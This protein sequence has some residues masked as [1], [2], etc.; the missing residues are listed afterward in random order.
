MTL[1]VSH[2]HFSVKNKD[3]HRFCSLSLLQHHV[4]GLEKSLTHAC[5]LHAASL[6]NASGDCRQ[7]LHHPQRQDWTHNAQRKPELVTMRKDYQTCCL[8]S[9]HH[10]KVRKFGWSLIIRVPSKLL[11]CA[12]VK[13]GQDRG[14]M[15]GRSRQNGL[16]LYEQSR[17]HHYCS[18]TESVL[19]VRSAWMEN[20]GVQYKVRQSRQD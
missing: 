18:V 20:A 10:I 19:G 5:S 2:S 1:Q 8:S 7:V 11:P 4:W 15:G 6:L 17:L 9:P 3:P 12:K 13:P 16:C 14:L